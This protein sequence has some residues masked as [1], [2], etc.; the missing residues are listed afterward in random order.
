MV[1]NTNLS[2]GHSLF[3]IP[4]KPNPGKAGVPFL[5][6]IED[7]SKRNNHSRL[8]LETERKK[9]ENLSKEAS[10]AVNE[11]KKQE[12]IQNWLDK[13]ESL[14]LAHEAQLAV[15]KLKSTEIK[16]IVTEELNS[17]L[18]ETKYQEEKNHL[19]RSQKESSI[20]PKQKFH[21]IAAQANP[22]LLRDIT[23]LYK[24]SSVDTHSL[25]R[26]FHNFNKKYRQDINKQDFSLLVDNLYKNLNDKV[27]VY[28][29]KTNI[30]AEKNLAGEFIRAGFLKPALNRL[31]DFAQNNDAKANYSEHAG[32]LFTD[33]NARLLQ[34]LRSFI[35]INNNESAKEVVLEAFKTILKHD[36]LKVSVFLKPEDVQA[37]FIEKEVKTLA[38][39][40][41]TFQE[42]SL[43]DKQMQKLIEARVQQLIKLG[44]DAKIS[45][46]AIDKLENFKSTTIPGTQLYIS[47][48]PIKEV[49][50]LQSKLIKN[51][52]ERYEFAPR[53]IKARSNP[54]QFLNEVQAINNII[55]NRDYSGK[56]TDI[57]I[58]DMDEDFKN[59]LNSFLEEFYELVDSHNI[60]LQSNEN[61]DKLKQDIITMKNILN[62]SN[63]KNLP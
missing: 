3:R 38:T 32:A 37:K 19:K 42:G 55:F 56:I 57:A 49:K 10:N 12:R 27:P 59:K 13:E 46:Q 25:A 20:K 40:K 50:D 31:I 53:K 47:L 44:L 58:N 8:K 4:V 1:D 17:D 48:L 43:Q 16:P 23:K 51:Y 2:K 15:E 7:F 29:D 41:S 62:Q 33:S 63:Q 24:Y 26:A 28:S 22:N 11:L 6:S 18:F 52:L 61:E 9:L 5:E 21:E 14:N 34:S 39:M 60:D 54:S 45:V 30:A 36:E 35:Y